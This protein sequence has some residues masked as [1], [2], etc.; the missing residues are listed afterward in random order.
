MKI[1]LSK[2]DWKEDDTRYAHVAIA[3]NLGRKSALISGSSI[4]LSIT[5]S[6]FDSSSCSCIA[7]LMSSGDPHREQKLLVGEFDS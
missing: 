5:W 2:D 4:R 3:L 6:I 7:V 1:T